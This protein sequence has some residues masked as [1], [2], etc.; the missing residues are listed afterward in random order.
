MLGLGESEREIAT[1][2]QDLREAGCSFLTLGQY[3]QPSPAHLPVDRFVRPEEFESWKEKALTMGFRQV[4]SGPFVR[5]SY[6]AD[7]LYEASQI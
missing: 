1:T 5:S 4:A 2:L 6:H 3:L 7:H